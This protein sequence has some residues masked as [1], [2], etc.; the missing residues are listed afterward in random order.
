MFLASDES[1]YIPGTDIVVDGGWFSSAPYLA[2]ERSHH[3]LQLPDTKDKA[4]P[5][6]ALPWIPPVAL[7]KSAVTACR[8]A[9][10]IVE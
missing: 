2:N 3:M 7:S 6:A 9:V 8:Q 5:V 10:S 4:E 1:S